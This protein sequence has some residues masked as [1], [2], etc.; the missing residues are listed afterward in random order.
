M[1]GSPQSVASESAKKVALLH[2]TE[3]REQL[4]RLE[5]H[6]CGHWE[7]DIVPDDSEVRGTQSGQP[8]L[9]FDIH[10]YG[11]TSVTALGDDGMNF[12]LL[13]FAPAA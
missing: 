9:A 12:I 8:D 6:G 5:R 7:I 10:R 1:A 2:V 3:L 11:V 13:R 4:E